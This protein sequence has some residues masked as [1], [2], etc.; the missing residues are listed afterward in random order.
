[1][2]ANEKTSYY[3]TSYVYCIFGNRC[4]GNNTQKPA[5]PKETTATPQV[6]GQ[7]K[8]VDISIKNFAFL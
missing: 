8:I 5:A 6:T 2:R 3:F 1:V 7:G 4:T